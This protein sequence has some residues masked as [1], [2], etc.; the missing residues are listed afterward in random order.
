MTRL[1]ALLVALWVPSAVLAFNEPDGFRGVPWGATEEQMRSSVSI[2][3]ACS[4]YSS[5]FKYLG[6]RYCPALLSLG[7][8]RVRAV[9]SFRANRLTRVGIHFASKDFDQ[10]ANIFVERYGAPTY[11][12]RDR[13]A[14]DGKRTSVVL[15]RYLDNNPTRGHA[16]ITTNAETETMKRLREQQTKDAA[17]DL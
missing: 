3:Q 17:K 14:W 16:T 15:Y 8:V 6:D 2:E 4:D 10:L 12:D 13:L 5:G 9:Y 1:A 7:T 11:R